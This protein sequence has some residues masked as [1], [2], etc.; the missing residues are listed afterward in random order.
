MENIKINPSKDMLDIGAEITKILKKNFWLTEKELKKVIDNIYATGNEEL[1]LGLI[2]IYKRFAGYD[3]PGMEKERRQKLAKRAILSTY[4]CFVEAT[5]ATKER[6][7]AL[8]DE[9]R[10]LGVTPYS[11]ALKSNFTQSSPLKFKQA[12][13]DLT[14]TEYQING[15][16]STLF[17][18]EE[19]DSLF[20]DCAT[21]AYGISS[22][23]L[24]DVLDVLSEFSWDRQTK[25]Y[26]AEP[27]SM[28]RRCKG[29]VKAN[30]LK[31]LDNIEY[32]YSRF[33]PSPF[34][35][36]DLVARVA[37]SP[38]ILLC[39]PENI[40][41]F[42]KNLTAHLNDL[43]KTYKLKV[44]ASY[45]NNMVSKLSDIDKFTQIDKI[46]SQK[47]AALKIVLVDNLGAENALECL[48]DFN[49]LY[50]DPRVLNCLFAT[51]SCEDLATIKNG[52]KINKL[53]FLLKN[54]GS[55]L[56][57]NSSN[58]GISGPATPPQEKKKGVQRNTPK[59]IDPN[60]FAKGNYSKAQSLYRNLSTSE[61]AEFDEIMQNLNAKLADDRVVKDEASAYNA[62]FTP[63][64][65]AEFAK[66][67]KQEA[68]D[69]AKKEAEFE[70]EFAAEL[71]KERAANASKTDSQNAPNTAMVANGAAND[72]LSVTLA[73][74]IKEENQNAQQNAEE[75]AKRA[76]EEAQKAD[77]ETLIEIATIYPGQLR[78]FIEEDEAKGDKQEIRFIR[79][80]DAKQLVNKLEKIKQNGLESK[81][82]NEFVRLINDFSEIL[83]IFSDVKELPIIKDLNI[84]LAQNK[85]YVNDLANFYADYNKLVEYIKRGDTVG[86][87]RKVAHI[88]YSITDIVKIK[89]YLFSNLDQRSLEIIGFA[90]FANSRNQDK[91]KAIKNLNIIS[92]DSLF[93]AT[94]KIIA[95]L[96]TAALEET[97]AN[98]PKF[99]IIDKPYKITDF[100]DMNRLCKFLSYPLGTVD[101]AIS[102][103]VIND[104]ILYM[105]S[106]DLKTSQL[107]DLENNLR[108]VVSPFMDLIK[109]Y[110]YNNDGYYIET[111]TNVLFRPSKIDK[112]LIDKLQIK[113]YDRYTS[114]KDV[115]DTYLYNMQS[116]NKV[117]DKY[118]T[119]TPDQINPT[120]PFEFE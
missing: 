35:R 119:K 109:A 59:K 118:I 52:K 63:E 85:K 29:L 45:V 3:I 91:E 86:F 14:Q 62:T 9:A 53:E 81:G 102:A 10:A 88:N 112:E 106:D 69:K 64:E 44:S 80:I 20:E 49:I 42:E 115:F 60:K 99:G 104:F 74:I 117:I 105:N 40:K 27:V 26:I 18:A 94:S 113:V 72:N 56:A 38:S 90:D 107:I 57:N 39:N 12:V 23:K 101:M 22:Q 116:S 33:T 16:T 43:V 31:L 19:I 65:E 95:S 21:L 25:S 11:I 5:D 77:D 103:T 73:N 87:A 30:P 70:T 78:Y 82:C 46:D 61:K 66:L 1:A 67:V 37:I 100:I 58:G 8:L 50:S 4:D 84:I 111:P 36:A 110:G 28:I 96:A 92:L 51:L 108:G 93:G 2:D 75:E 13:A 98:L 79:K 32:L 83:T 97:T 76:A 34:S 24:Q 6:F 7:F 89:N 47:I 54:T 17:K 114:Q 120:P 55:T 68:E 41:N 71:E 48:T 15:K